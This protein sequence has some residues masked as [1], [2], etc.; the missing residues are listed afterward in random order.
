MQPGSRV[1]TSIQLRHSAVCSR[2]LAVRT[3]FWRFGELR[4]GAG[5]HPRI[6]PL[7]NAAPCLLNFFLFA[8][9]MQDFPIRAHAAEADNDRDDDD[10]P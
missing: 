4:V 9:L 3:A 2:I 10:P 6:D 8:L 5:R 7:L 1:Q